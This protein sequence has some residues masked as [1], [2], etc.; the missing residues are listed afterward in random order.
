MYA[1]SRPQDQGESNGKFI[2]EIIQAMK[3]TPGHF[4]EN[5]GRILE[6]VQSNYMVW[7][8]VLRMT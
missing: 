4:V 2:H 3:Q 6:I 7:S 5:P 1:Q 8:F